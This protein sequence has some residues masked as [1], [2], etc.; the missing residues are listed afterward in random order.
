MKGM[1][2]EC[3]FSNGVWGK[4]KG[5]K[6]KAEMRMRKLF[7]QSMYSVMKVITGNIAVRE[8]RVNLT[9]ISKT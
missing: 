4:W 1:S 8:E 2:L 9:S 7:L 3:Y 6:L 5:M